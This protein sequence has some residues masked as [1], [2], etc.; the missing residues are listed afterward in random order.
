MQVPIS[1]S[2]AALGTKVEIPTPEGPTTIRIP[3]STQSGV[4]LRVKGQGMTIPRSGQRGDLIAEIQVVTPL[5]QDE[6]SKELLREL[7]QIN[8]AEIR[9]GIWR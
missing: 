6:R 9:K 7:A 8:D 1:F 2:E 4:K 3:P 5:I